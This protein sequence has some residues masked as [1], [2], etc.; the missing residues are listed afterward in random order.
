M[1]TEILLRSKTSLAKGRTIAFLRWALSENAQAEEKTPTLRPHGML[2]IPWPP[3]APLVSCSKC[4]RK[5]KALCVNIL[6]YTAFQIN[7]RFIPFPLRNP[8]FPLSLPWY[9]QRRYCWKRGHSDRH[10]LMLIG[11]LHVVPGKRYYC[12]TVHTCNWNIFGLLASLKDGNRLSVLWVLFFGDFPCAAEQIFPLRIV[13]SSAAEHKRKHDDSCK[14][15]QMLTRLSLLRSVL[16]FC[17]LNCDKWFATLLFILCW[18]RLSFWQVYVFVIILVLHAISSSIWSNAAC[19]R[20]K[21]KK[22]HSFCKWLQMQTIFNA[23]RTMFLYVAFET[24]GLGRCAFVS[25]SSFL[26]KLQSSIW[27]V[28]YGKS[29]NSCCWSPFFFED[30]FAVCLFIVQTAAFSLFLF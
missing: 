29:G 27:V 6:F 7:P 16:V 25:S 30:I 10:V 20:T 19:H 3:G 4:K 18:N 28:A 5:P 9:K 22:Y 14:R 12:W 15:L 23:L 21:L 2:P 17:F 24:G 8:L 11:T 13:D 1:Q 26:L